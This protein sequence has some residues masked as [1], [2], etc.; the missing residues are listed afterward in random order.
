[1]DPLDILKRA[2]RILWGYR[3]LWVFA[4]ILGLTAGGG[5]G[6]NGNLFQ[7]RM[8]R[9]ERFPEGLRDFQRFFRYELPRL[10]ISGDL[11][12]TVV[13][14]ILGIVIALL[15][16][17][18]VFTIARYVAETA[19]IRMVDAHERTAERPGVQ[20][21]FRL[22]WS[23]AAWRMFLIDLIVNLPIF[24]LVL[25][26]V[27]AG[28]VTALLIAQERGTAAVPAWI[29]F[30]IFMLLAILVVVVLSIVL[31]LFR[32][33]FWRASALEDAGVG[34]AF[35]RGFDL[36]KRNWQ[37]VGMM[38]LILVGIGIAWAIALFIAFFLLIPVYVITGLV[39]LIAGGLPALLVYGISNLLLEEWL[40]WVLAAVVG[41][42]IFFLVTFSPLLF[43]SGLGTVF[44]SSVWTLTY[45]ELAALEA[46]ATA[47]EPPA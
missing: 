17:A 46:F 23:R 41:L 28:L 35:R 40:P 36:V 31:N 14:V 19:V 4:L 38:W 15:V 22:G 10:D 24:F 8:D 42:P 6:G 43:L 7:Y 32:Q 25:F 45:R 33:F 20:A 12:A 37:N 13:W 44:T 18:I 39:G 16:L 26:L 21:G 11:W 27:L 30:A 2:W 47:A 9:T 1:M 3:A 5:G 29:T 34:Q